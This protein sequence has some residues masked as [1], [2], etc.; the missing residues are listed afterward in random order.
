MICHDFHSYF[1]VNANFCPENAFCAHEWEN[2]H[3][4]ENA[5]MQMP[6]LNSRSML[7]YG[8]PPPAGAFL[9]SLFPAAHLFEKAHDHVKT[10]AI[11]KRFRYNLV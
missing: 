2:A 4:H 10:L 5:S 1:F 9:M 11:M 8:F 6:F 3:S 7:F